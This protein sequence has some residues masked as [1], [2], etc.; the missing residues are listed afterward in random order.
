MASDIMKQLGEVVERERERF[1]VP[2]IS[3]G[4]LRDGEVEAAGFGVTSL[5]TRQ[6]VTSDTLFQIGSNSKV[7][8][9]TLLM[10]LV[11][12]GTLDLDASPAAYLPDLQVPDMTA[13]PKMKVRHLVSHQTGIFGDYFEDFGWGDEALARSVAQIHT[14]PQMYQPEELWSYTNINFNIAGLII[15][16]LT[17]Q[18]FETAMRE[19]VFDPLAM[20]RS[21]YFP[22]DVFAYPHGVGH[23]PVTPGADEVEVARF[24]WLNRALGAAGA[25]HSTVHDVLAFDRFHLTGETPTGKP[26]LSEAARMAM[27]E[28]QIQAANFCEHWGL[29]WWIYHVDGAKIIGH[30]GGTNGFI[31]RNTV[32]PER[33]MA[34][35]IFTNSLRGGAAI[36]P[37]ERWML[38]NFAGL[39]ET[40]PAVIELPQDQLA[41]FA[42]T[43][44]NRNAQITVSAQN[45]GLR[46]QS[47]SLT[48]QN[49]DAEPVVYPPVD[50]QPVGAKEFMATKGDHEGNRLDFIENPDG[51]IRFI[52]TG[53]RVFNRE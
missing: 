49:P 18:T 13:L 19:R 32:I 41:R 48:I 23:T 40:D 7:F 53:G 45:G 4:V 44:S 9:T 22:W 36:R 1:N 2:G 29:G 52:R 11:D 6:P 30:G 25:I 17:G 33:N 21:F 51:S 28:P 5:E 38:Q 39:T 12:E 15:E 31:T 47:R 10:T 43:Y 16:K 8:T 50:Y 46:L 24:F 3:V 20:K 37:I 35:A 34:W 26:V 27:R 14:L 42:G